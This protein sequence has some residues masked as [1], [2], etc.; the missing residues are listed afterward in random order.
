MGSRIKI[1]GESVANMIAAGEVVEA[2]FSVVKELVE[3]A[4]D[5][6]ATEI[7]VDIKGGGG[8]LVRVSDNGSGMNRDDALAAFDRFATSKLTTAED[9]G[10]ISTLGFR[11]E[12]LPS[13]ASVSRVR[14]ATCEDG[15]LEGTEVNLV[16]GEVR[17]VRPVGRSRGTTVEVSSLF[18]NT[19][20]RR[21]FLK[22]DS[23]EVRR[24]ME[25]MT[26]YAVL[27][28]SI[29]FDVAIDG[30][31]SLGL[32]A[33]DNLAQRVAGVLGSS[34]SAE[35]L[36][37]SHAEDGGSIEGMVGRPTIARPR[38]AQQV[39]AIN[40]RPIRSR[41]ITAAVRSGYGE[42]LPHT[43][44][45][46]VFLLLTIDGS[47]V[48]V[49]VHP[50]KREVRFGNS[51]P[52]FGLV[53]NAVRAAL[54][55]HDTAPT[56][57]TYEVRAGGRTGTAPQSAAV[58]TQE[59]PFPTLVRE[60]ESAVV[61]QEDLRAETA[62]DVH[63]AKFWQLHQSYVFVQT[64]EGVLVVDQ[65]AAHERVLYEK[66]RV[67]LSGAAEAGPSQQLLFPVAVELSPGEWE[68]LEG[69]VPLLDKL[70]FTIR[71]MSGRTVLLE[72]VPGAFPKWPHDRIL[73]DI[74]TE[75]PSGR[76]DV[77]DL[78]ESIARTVACKAAI[79]AGD[80]LTQEEM[81]ALI[82]QLF[83]TELPYSCPHGRPTFMRMTSEELDKRF[84]RT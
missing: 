10:N 68:S 53:E 36:P 56:L 23:V 84:G 4:L 59:L 52:I 65:H 83:A 49:N 25:L 12:A 27:Y 5:A 73:H 3:N 7:T 70:G 47:L 58:A 60:T 42:L 20:A 61:S 81:R 67:S 82:D 29:R 24:I 31:L 37:V 69:V 30:K 2:P 71:S 66:A 55:S 1:L 43:R 75:L 9:L 19:P 16:G 76:T 50:T 74:L 32:M 40:G 72:A 15:D 41:L 79:K 13:I 77:R 35:M 63:H 78:V 57:S 33:T 28:P 80:R 45:P 11:G 21:K 6:G 38:G 14:L 17:D 39:V 26:E 48:D 8:D 34:V 46:I 54:M 64:R 44:H 18:F 22:S 62:E 51:R